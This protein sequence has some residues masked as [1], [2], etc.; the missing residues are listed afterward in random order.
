MNNVCPIC[1]CSATKAIYYGLPHYL[2]D[3]VDCSCLF[4]FWVIITQFLPFNGVFML[5][6]GSYIPA[7]CSWF[8]G[9]GVEDE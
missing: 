5:Y 8:T 2:C 9:E 7:L 4:G 1:N 3:N 6:E